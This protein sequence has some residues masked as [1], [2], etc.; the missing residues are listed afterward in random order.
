MKTFKKIAMLICSCVCAVCAVIGIT[1]LSA[2]EKV[3]ADAADQALTT[4]YVPAKAN[5]LTEVTMESIAPVNGVTPEGETVDYVDFNGLGIALD[6]YML[7]EYKGNNIPTVA[8]N[9]T[10][11]YSRWNGEDYSTTGY[12][13]NANY[14]VDN[15][16]EVEYASDNLRFSKGFNTIN[17]NSI[18]TS[19]GGH[20]RS[21]DKTYVMVMGIRR[22]NYWYR[23]PEVYIY[24]VNDDG[25][26]TEEKTWT[27][28][29]DHTS[30]AARGEHVVIYPKIGGTSATF[31]YS[32]PKNSIQDVVQS[33]GDGVKYKSALAEK[34]NL[35]DVSL[36]SA[37]LDKI[38]ARTGE[39][40]N[41]DY[42][43]FD[44]YASKSA[45]FLVD[46]VGQNVPNF[47]FAAGQAY[48]TWPA[49]ASAPD[50]STAG[51]LLEQSTRN[52]A[53]TA[54]RHS[55]G[56]AVAKGLKTDEYSFTQE[57]FTGIA[58]YETDKHYIMVIGLTSNAW[59]TFNLF[60]ENEG[61]LSLVGSLDKAS[62]ASVYGGITNTKLVIYPNM[63]YGPNTINFKYAIPQENTT[64]LINE[65]PDGY[66]YKAQLKQY[67]ISNTATIEKEDGTTVT[68]TFKGETYTLPV[69]E[70]AGFIGYD[71]NGALYGAGS[72]ITAATDIT[73]KEVCLDLAMEEGASVRVSETTTE[74]GG[75]RFSVTVDSAVATA[76]A[77]NIAIYGCIIATDQ[78][79]G[80]FEKEETGAKTKALTEFV[81]ENG[82][83]VYRITLTNILYTNYNRAFSALAYATI[84]YADGTTATVVTDYDAKNNS[85]SIYEVSVKAL[86]DTKTSYTGTPLKILKEYVGF[87]VG[88]VNDNGTISVATEANDELKDT[89][90]KYTIE[91]VGTTVT[92]TLT[93]I[94]ERLQSATHIPVTI[95]NGTEKTR[96]LVAATVNA[97]T[98]TAVYTIA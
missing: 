94:P 11:A 1:S 28:A 29:S 19:Y 86:N 93:D 6:I 80:T 70:S 96:T 42:V 63:G 65:L 91:Q 4:A 72:V 82:T 44:D 51:I 87:S 32:A 15:N 54:N 8:I 26:L 58:N 79:D 66:T 64:D 9:A 69:S 56:L 17:T 16:G 67:F 83:N 75:L 12:I 38:T 5:G 95:Y 78:I 48:S 35:G 43:L 88:L 68:E 14:E 59:L 89:Y 85:R 55:Q 27:N 81:T 74:Y 57:T 76:Y 50:H 40:T 45:Y 20:L 47:A 90:R 21:N 25:T 31:K 53:D 22:V 36:T 73:V 30:S 49:N 2:S 3:T 98:A 33:L 39:A 97:A 52:A 60:E 41:V 92:I 34:F 61:V 13:F 37:S 71:Y 77:D 84:T 62:N 7:F 10:Q 23:Y 24:S 46:F 18:V